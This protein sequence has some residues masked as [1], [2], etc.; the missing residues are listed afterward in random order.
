MSNLLHERKYWNFQD[1]KW[2]FAETTRLANERERIS[3]DQFDD[4]FQAHK[5][6]KDAKHKKDWSFPY[7]DYQAKTMK[8]APTYQDSQKKRKECITWWE[9]NEAKKNAD[10]LFIDAKT[11][12]QFIDR[13]SRT[14]Q[15]KPKSKSKSKPKS[16]NC[17]DTNNC[18][19][20]ILEDR[21]HHIQIL[22]IS[23]QDSYSLQEIKKAFRQQALVQHPDHDKTM[24]ASERFIKLQSSYEY[25]CKTI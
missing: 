7:F 16:N 9:Q 25:L 1:G 8:Y 23:I 5:D 6:V 2:C 20:N 15:E 10:N 12:Q 3:R 13:K 21:S 4:E 14:S 24:G 18:T 17:Q 11:W 22:G 19:N